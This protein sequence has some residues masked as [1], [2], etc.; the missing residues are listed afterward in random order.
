MRFRIISQSWRYRSLIRLQ[1]LARQSLFCASCLLYWRNP[2]KE[3]ASNLLANPVAIL[4]P[5][6]IYERVYH[7][8]AHHW[9]TTRE[10]MSHFSSGTV[11]AVTKVITK[12]K[13]YI[14][15]E[16]LR[17]FRLIFL[18]CRLTPTRKRVEQRDVRFPNEYRTAK[19]SGWPSI[20]W[21]NEPK[22]ESEMRQPNS[23]QM[24]NP[25]SRSLNERWGKIELMVSSSDSPERDGILMLMI[26]SKIQLYEFSDKARRI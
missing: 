15:A 14:P 18:N 17:F 11:Y 23:K 10:T 5:K 26:G 13:T 24:P 12:Q 19:R 22:D 4:R 21:V 25:I 3:Y 6:G 8:R 16:T 9:V 2:W 20:S 1:I 7:K